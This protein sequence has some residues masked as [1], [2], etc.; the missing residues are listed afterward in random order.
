MLVLGVLACGQ[1]KEPGAESR[2]PPPDPTPPFASGSRLRARVLDGGGDAVK[3]VE[4]HD[5]ELDAPC[6]FRVATDG[7][8]RCLPWKQEASQG[9]GNVDVRYLDPSCSTAV[10]LLEADALAPER[11][12]ELAQISECARPE[13]RYQVRRVG[14]LVS[15]DEL[16]LFRRDD[17]SACVGADTL[18]AATSNIVVRR[19]EEVVPLEGF[20]PAERVLPEGGGRLS[21]ITLQGSDGSLQRTGVWDSGRQEEC[22]PLW[23]DGAPCVPRVAWIDGLYSDATCKV[24]TAYVSDLTPLSDTCS[25][26]EFAVDFSH[27]WASCSSAPSYDVYELGS[28][29]GDAFVLVEGTCTVGDGGER[30]RYAVGRR[31]EG[32]F[33]SVA[34]VRM[35]SGRITVSGVVGADGARLD[36]DNTFYDEEAGTPCVPQVACGGGVF[37][38]P[39]PLDGYFSDAACTQ[40]AVMA[41]TSAC[42]LPD[43]WYVSMFEHTDSCW[44]GTIGEVGVALDAST[45]YAKTNGVD[46]VPEAVAEGWHLRPVRPS[47][48]AAARLVDRIE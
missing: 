18:N 36:L 32:V 22:T 41:A 17:A 16:P 14:D 40:P 26:P 47:A 13:D 39:E 31:A 42:G 21:A 6:I 11:T 19:L 4:W 15:F 37:C 12:V 27:T 29:V 33:A 20:V 48:L 43:P 34:H 44:D 30:T 3:F 1:T 38:R 5:S 2:L 45:A 35:G 8:L 23:D 28:P 7:V 25:N 24:A 46:C 9:W 10:I